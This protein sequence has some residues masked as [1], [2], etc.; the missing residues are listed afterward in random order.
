MA[1]KNPGIQGLHCPDFFISF[2]YNSFNLSVN[3]NKY[4]LGAFF[5]TLLSSVATTCQRIDGKMPVSLLLIPPSMTV[6][7]LMFLHLSCKW[8]KP[9]HM[10]LLVH[11]SNFVSNFKDKSFFR[12]SF[13]ADYSGFLTSKGSRITLRRYKN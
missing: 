11:S 5:L 2:F 9:Q 12:L 4:Y 10:L 6:L 1:C 3:Q 8:N 7:Y 13:N